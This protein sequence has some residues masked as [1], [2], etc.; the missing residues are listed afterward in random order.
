MV[1]E[2]LG[3][4]GRVKRELAVLLKRDGFTSVAEAVGADH[5]MGAQG[6]GK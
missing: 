2:G 5:R 3:L 1:F 6:L 4:L